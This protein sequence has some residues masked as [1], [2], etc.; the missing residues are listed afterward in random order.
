MYLP[1]EPEPSSVPPWDGSVPRSTMGP[2][3][4]CDRMQIVTFALAD[5]RRAGYCCILEG[6]A[7]AEATML[8]ARLHSL[9]GCPGDPCA[10][11]TAVR[12]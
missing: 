12:W 5:E 11:C 3:D 6:I 8:A 7:T 10:V 2:C 1:A 4:L 9:T